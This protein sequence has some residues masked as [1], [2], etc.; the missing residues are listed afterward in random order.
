M[1]KKILLLSPQPFYQERGT[2]IA[3][4][5]ILNVLQE[6]GYHVDVLTYPE[7]EDKNYDNVNIFRLPKV[8]GVRKIPPGFSWK[9]IVYS[10]L[11]VPFAL[12]LVIR[13]NY[14][15]VH[16]IEE[17]CFIALITKLLFNLNYIYDMDSSLSQQLVEKKPVLTPFYSVFKYLEKQVMRHATG[18]IAVC[19]SLVTTAE[20]A[21]NK[22]VLLLQDISL[23][24][25]YNSNINVTDLRSV[26]KMELP[27]ILYI[28]NLEPYQGIDLLLR[29]FA[30]A[31][32]NDSRAC[33]AIIGGVQEDI[34]RYS[35]SAKTLG[36]EEYVHLFGPRP[37]SD[38][39]AYLSQADILVSPR[40]LGNNT[41]MK[42]YTYLDSGKVVLATAIESHTQ[43]LND[44]VAY[45]VEPTVKGIA[46]GIDKLVR[47]DRLRL[48]LGCAGKLL[49]EKKHNWK[50]FRK[51][52]S[53]Y[54]KNVID[55]L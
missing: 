43:T 39:G 26:F 40:I 31:H 5:L 4:D 51:T 37:V 52:L 21:G 27:L 49:A 35:E 12:K 22:R 53:T 50:V 20:A 45:L 36:I 41:P 44:D 34:I 1:K 10:T 16:A 2:P 54:Y 18:V 8:Y 28:G 32:K 38:L 9:K 30:L 3:V 55:T 11:M 42:I 46:T 14:I 23:L 29:G 6:K 47:S 48:Q 17:S 7:G 25:R 33:L 19:P 15:A 13:H 24:N